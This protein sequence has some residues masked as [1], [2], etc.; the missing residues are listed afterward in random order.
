MRMV[1]ADSSNRATQ[2][3]FDAAFKVD[4]NQFSILLK[5][6]ISLIAG[7]CHPEEN[8]NILHL[9]ASEK[10]ESKILKIIELI[11]SSP[12]NYNYCMYF[13]KAFKAMDFQGNTPL[14]LSISNNNTEIFQIFCGLYYKCLAQHDYSKSEIWLGLVSVIN[15]INKQGETALHIAAKYTNIDAIRIL[16]HMG[17]DINIQNYEGRTAL[18]IVARCNC[19]NIIELLLRKGADIKIVDNNG[20]TPAHLVSQMQGGNIDAQKNTLR[21]LAL[22]G[23]NPQL[24]NYQG[25]TALDEMYMRNMS[26]W[27]KIV[28]NRDIESAYMAHIL[29]KHNITSSFTLKEDIRR[30]N[31][32]GCTVI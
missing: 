4:L 28:D 1:T 21:L 16:L 5:N 27:S 19:F 32:F 14:M 10:V 9:I 15:F 18:H 23:N 20:N 30:N 2:N 3:F 7:I 11:Y 26:I 13:L 31:Y 24:Q 29:R 22:H 6:D 17:A 12:N 25:Y 8:C